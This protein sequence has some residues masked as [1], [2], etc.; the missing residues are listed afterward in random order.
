MV[1]YQSLGLNYR[2]KFRFVQVTVPSGPSRR[3]PR[4]LASRE[5]H[6]DAAVTAHRP[7]GLWLK[8]RQS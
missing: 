2:R 3:L 7:E 6:G 8:S 5:R 4:L 1:A